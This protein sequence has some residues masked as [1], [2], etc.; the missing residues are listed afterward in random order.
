MQKNKNPAEVLLMGLWRSHTPVLNLTHL[1]TFAARARGSQT[2]L[3]TG[4][5]WGISPRA[6]WPA[7]APDTGTELGLVTTWASGLH[8]LSRGLECRTKFENN[9][10]GSSR[11]AHHPGKCGP[12][13]AHQQRLLCPFPQLVQFPLPQPA[14]FLTQK[15][16]AISEYLVCLPWMW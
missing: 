13:R 6:P 15:L 3:H 5:R 11:V 7:P 9:C 4:T 12:G 16:P 2:L 1:S 10:F 14:S 8:K